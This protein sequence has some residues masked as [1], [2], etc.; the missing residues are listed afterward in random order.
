LGFAGGG[1]TKVEFRLAGRGGIGVAIIVDGRLMK[2]KFGV[3][4]RRRVGVPIVGARDATD[5]SK[6]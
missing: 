4:V 1:L 6:V 3:V 5:R 2:T